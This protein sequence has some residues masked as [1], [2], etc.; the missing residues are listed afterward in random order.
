[1]EI[2]LFAHNNLPE[3]SIFSIRAGTVRRQAA[4]SNNRP[5][6]F[7]SKPMD[8]PLKVEVFKPVG[9][10]YVVLRPGEEQYK[11]SFK[12]ME[13][14]PMSCEVHVKPVQDGAAPLPPAEENVKESSTSAK[15]AKDYLE[16]HQVMQFVQA[17]LQTL[18]KDKPTDPYSYMA[19]HF[20]NGYEPSEQRA[21]VP[22]AAPPT[23]GAA[24]KAPP[25]AAE[26]EADGNAAAEAAPAAEASPKADVAAATLAA[27]ATPAGEAAAA[28]DVPPP[29]EAAKPD[30]APVQEAVAETAKAVP[31]DA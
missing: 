14:A 23:P 12:G 16:G 17:L 27:E 26:P 15:E 18:I 25:P 22:A 13:E 9:T 28:A 3:G 6:R 21:P 20:S 19:R 4:V 7:P 5:F 24:E 8:S 30:A 2:S 11:V 31:A 10:A 29:V 1:M